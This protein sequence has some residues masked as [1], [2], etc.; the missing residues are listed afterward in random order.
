M[1]APTYISSSNIEAAG[2]QLGKLYLRFKSG[3]A[4]SY[5]GVPFDYFATLTKIESAGKFFARFIR[6]KFRY[7]KLEQD[8]FGA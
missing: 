8:P 2:Y 5:D 3:G 6:G 7:H 4:Y 1:I